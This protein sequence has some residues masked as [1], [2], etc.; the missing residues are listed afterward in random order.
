MD[1]LIQRLKKESKYLGGGIIKADS[2]INHQLD[3]ELTCQMGFEFT[4]V[5]NE[6]G[7]K[8][9]TRILTAE[10]SGIAPAL[11]T[12]TSL[13]VP[14]VFARKKPPKTMSEELFTADAPSRTKDENVTLHVSSSYLKKNDRV[15]IIDDFLATG[16]TIEALASI[17]EKSG[18]TLCGVGCV[19][20]KVYEQGRSRLNKLGIPIVTLAKIDIDHENSLK[21]Y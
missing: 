8:G 10:V 3:P 7:V 5:F 6:A 15:I 20:E 1:D 13:G 4:R 18:A 16:H 14:M 21:I 12:A 2:V 11:A 9:I 19:I 17:V